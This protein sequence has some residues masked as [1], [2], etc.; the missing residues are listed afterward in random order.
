L[1]TSPYPRLRNQSFPKLT[2]SDI[3]HFFPSSF[4]SDERLMEMAHARVAREIIVLYQTV[5]DALKAKP[6]LAKLFY[7][8]KCDSYNYRKDDIAIPFSRFIRHRF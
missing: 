2:F 3:S 8:I 6:L 1:K 4:L 7:V 5:H